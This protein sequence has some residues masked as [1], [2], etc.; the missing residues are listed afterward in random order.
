MGKIVELSKELEDIEEIV[1]E[2]DDEELDPPF[3]CPCVT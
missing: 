3:L 1:Q 2:F